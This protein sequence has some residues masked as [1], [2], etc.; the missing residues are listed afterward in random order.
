MPRPY[1]RR[2]PARQ[3]LIAAV[4]IVTLTLAGCAG[5]VDESGL[6][7]DD[8]AAFDTPELVAA[9]AADGVRD[10]GARAAAVRVARDAV[11]FVE[12][13]YEDFQLGRRF[14]IEILK[15]DADT[16][17]VLVAAA[18]DGLIA[19]VYDQATDLITGLAADQV[20][21]DAN[22][23]LA[24]R[25]GA[26]ISSSVFGALRSV[27]QDGFFGNAFIG[28][29]DRWAVLLGVL[30]TAR[31]TGAASGSF[32]AELDDAELAGLAPAADP[33]D[34]PDDGDALLAATSDQVID[35]LV[36]ALYADPEVRELLTGDED[37]DRDSFAADPFITS[38][39]DLQVEE[40]ARI[41]VR[42]IGELLDRPEPGGFG[43][44]LD[45]PPEPG[46]FGGILEGS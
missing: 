8:V 5:E 10:G 42:A 37:I 43:E 31:A 15:S 6:D 9:V 23:R 46:G 11:A 36:D 28:N 3:I 13:V 1:L 45:P 41:S 30:D 14:V 20:V 4:A 2:R 25:A 29:D 44:L 7:A 27:A 16:L 12:I 32:V 40:V 21:I 17:P 38:V 33:P 19:G 26:F 22:Q 35:L 18:L 39:L 34:V 24:I